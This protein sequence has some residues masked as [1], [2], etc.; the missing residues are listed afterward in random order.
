[1]ASPGRP[2]IVIAIP[3]PAIHFFAASKEDVEARAKPGQARPG[4][5]DLKTR[6]LLH[7]S[8]LTHEGTK[9]LGTLA[10][11]LRVLR[12]LPDAFVERLDGVGEFLRTEVAMRH[13]EPFELLV[14]LQL[15]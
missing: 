7:E 14:L 3:A 4:R 10:G 2:S 12:R 5:D 15:D 8:L 13:S 9:R 1:M 11:R 6:P